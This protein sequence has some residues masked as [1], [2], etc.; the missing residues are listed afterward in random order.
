MKEKANPRI[1][2]AQVVQ[3]PAVM[4]IIDQLL[5]TGFR[6]VDCGWCT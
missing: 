2:K 3:F 1:H 4:Y 5:T 6:L